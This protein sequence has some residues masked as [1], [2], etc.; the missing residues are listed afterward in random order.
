MYALFTPDDTQ[1]LILFS[2]VFFASI[3]HRYDGDYDK[4]SIERS[5]KEDSS[6]ISI[7]NLGRTIASKSRH[8]FTHYMVWIFHMS[9]SGLTQLCLLG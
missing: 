5:L 6:S 3:Y 4:E 9:K 1:I 2:T 8:F 7:F